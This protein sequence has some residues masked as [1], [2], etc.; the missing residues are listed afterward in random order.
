MANFNVLPPALVVGR[1]V[2]ERVFFAHL[3]NLRDG[4]EGRIAFDTETTGIDIARDVP[5][6]ASVSDGVSRWLMTL[7]QL[8]DPRFVELIEDPSRT[9]VMANAKFD[10]H[11][12]GQ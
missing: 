8:M 5:L 4:W 12:R 3:H 2:S 7:N 1:D 9:W 11:M 6:F 10:M